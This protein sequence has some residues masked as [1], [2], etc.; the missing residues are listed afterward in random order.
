MRCVSSQSSRRGRADKNSWKAKPNIPGPIIDALDKMKDCKVQIRTRA[1]DREEFYNSSFAFESILTWKG[2]MG[3]NS[4]A[5]NL[6]VLEVIIPAPGVSRRGMD[7]LDVLGRLVHISPL[8]NLGIHAAGRLYPWSQSR[9]GPSTR[10]TFGTVREFRWLFDHADSAQKKL[11][12]KGL[13]L[14]NFCLC[15][16]DEDAIRSMRNLFKWETL[17]KG[18]FTCPMFLQVAAEQDVQL[19][20]L[21]LHL[22]N[23]DDGARS[24]VDVPDINRLQAFLASQRNLHT[25]EISNGSQ[26]F[27][28][29]N[30]EEDMSLF[31]ALGRSLYS[32]IVRENEKRGMSPN[33]KRPLLSQNAMQQMGEKFS[34]LRTL[35][36]NLPFVN[37]MVYQPI[38]V[39]IRTFNNKH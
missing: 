13:R 6:R 3:L 19:R 7:M 2:L 14:T 26:V 23:P 11:N 17:Q 18:H 30:D 1:D 36:L 8:D 34:H 22:D 35:A 5:H 24:C 25:L 15:R 9:D 16:A 28:S 33:H 38:H 29:L 37:D 39:L 4:I 32:L 12:L 10:Y 20:S 31:E 27:D 21:Y